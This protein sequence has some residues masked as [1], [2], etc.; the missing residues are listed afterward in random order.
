MVARDEK[1]NGQRPAVENPAS[2][3]VVQDRFGLARADH[4][5]HQGGTDR[6]ADLEA[7]DLVVAIVIETDTRV[8]GVIRKRHSVGRH[9]SAGANSH[10]LVV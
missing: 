4:D 5:L 9:E 3:A 8:G 6:V 2:A 7:V 1:S 10:T